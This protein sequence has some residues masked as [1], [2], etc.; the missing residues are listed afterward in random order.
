[1]AR[2]PAGESPINVTHH[3]KGISF[4]AE[5]QDLVEHAK[6]NGAPSEVVQA[7]EAMPEQSYETMA[8]VMKGFK[9]AE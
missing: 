2:G 1:M 7:I 6:G 9:Q 8:D 3:L 4:P 5:K